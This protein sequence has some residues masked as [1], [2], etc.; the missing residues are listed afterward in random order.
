MCLLLA[1][2]HG[3]HEISKE[4][5]TS[6]VANECALYRVVDAIGS[7]KKETRRWVSNGKAEEIAPTPYYHHSIRFSFDCHSSWSFT[8]S[9]CSSSIQNSNSAVQSLVKLTFWKN[10]LSQRL[11]SHSELGCGMTVDHPLIIL[12]ASPSWRKGPWLYASLI[13]S[14]LLWISLNFRLSWLSTASQISSI[15]CYGVGHVCMS[16]TSHTIQ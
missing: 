8:R 5:S 16:D 15:V 13:P 2:H 10:E 3:G 9:F 7:F 1:A 4:L 6:T 12:S 11:Y 14:S